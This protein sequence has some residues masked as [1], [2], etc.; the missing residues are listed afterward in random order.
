MLVKLIITLF[1]SLFLSNLTF[2]DTKPVTTLPVT[3]TYCHDLLKYGN[4]A[5]ANLYLCRIGYIV[6]YNYETK[7]PRWVAYK[8]TNSSVSQHIKR[9]DHFQADPAVPIKYR[10]ELS[11]YHNNGYDRGHLAPYAAMS[12]SKE[13]A[14]ESFYLSNMSPQKAGL[15]RQGWEQLETDV[16]FWA[17]YKKEI[18]IYTGPI[19]KHVKSHKSIGKNKILVPEYFFKIIYAPKTNEAIAF[20]MPNAHVNKKDV[21]KYRVSI[22][23]IEQRTGLQFLTSLPKEQRQKLVNNVSKMWRT[24]YRS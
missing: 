9:H 23:N 21:A 7:Q 20:V 16:R 2:S 10:A 8:L 19:F 4:P 13:S 6:G 17:G 5:H 14:E 15:N 22:T 1:L 18:Y 3:T 24:S 11:D 12:F